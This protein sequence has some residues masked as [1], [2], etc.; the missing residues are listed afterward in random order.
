M[1]D[2]PYAV[3]FLIY[4]KKNDWSSVSI[5][6][7]VTPKF[8]VVQRLELKPCNW[9]TRSSPHQEACSTLTARCD[10]AISGSVSGAVVD[11]S[12]CCAFWRRQRAFSCYGKSYRDGHLT[13][14]RRVGRLKVNLPKAVSILHQPP[15][16]RFIEVRAHFCLWNDVKGKDL[17]EV[18]RFHDNSKNGSLIQFVQLSHLTTWWC[19]LCWCVPIELSFAAPASRVS[20]NQSLPNS[21]NW[22]KL[23]ENWNSSCWGPRKKVM[24]YLFCQAS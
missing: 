17:A 23:D 11:E 3:A 21:F 5:P 19:P 12:C 1:I 18:P 9:L 4:L 20:W 6:G 14:P 10:C 24:W 2:F 13:L 16:P 8:Y 7:W 15:H 22:R